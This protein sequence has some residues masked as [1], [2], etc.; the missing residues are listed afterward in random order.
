MAVYTAINEAQLLD[1]L[2]G[3]DLGTLKR[4]EG[5]RQGV[6]NT[7]YHLYLSGGRFIL[8]LFEKRTDPADLPFF[9]AFTDH[10]ARRGVLCPRALPGTDG[11]AIRALAGRPA[12]I[13]TYMEGTDVAPAAITPAHCAAV[14]DMLARM[15]GA[16]ASFVGARNNALGLAGWESLAART[17]AQADDVIPTLRGLIAT[18]LDYL[19]GAWP[20]DLPRGVVHADLFPDNVLFDR[21]DI[22][23]VID[24]YFSC[25]DFYAYDLAIVINAW[26]FDH[27]G[28]FRQDRLTS[29]LGA[30]ESL[31]PLSAAERAALPDLLRGAALRFLLTRLYDWVNHDPAAVVTPK[32]PHEYFAKLVFHQNERIAA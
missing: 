3:Y 10:L 18:E 23:G 17:A 11:A 2:A 13:I 14:G 26:C 25:T 12:A 31:R 28:I 6:E 5:I 29:L 21:M 22:G 16:A 20:V 1:F 8:T 7:N 4:F 9:F 27:T 19:R 15:H 32:E 30:Y 24:F